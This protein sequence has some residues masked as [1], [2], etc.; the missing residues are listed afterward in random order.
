MAMSTVSKYKNNINL[1]V[2]RSTGGRPVTL[3]PTSQH[4]ARRSIHSGV[5]KTAREIAN[6][7]S[8]D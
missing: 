7:L 2:L 5:C 3:P 8:L 1:Y 4:R 6:E